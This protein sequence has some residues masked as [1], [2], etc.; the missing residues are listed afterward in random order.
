MNMKAL[1]TGGAGF[2]GSHIVEELL[3]QKHEVVVIDN[4]VTGKQEN[5]PSD[6]KFYNAD[7][8]SD[9][10]SIFTIEKPDIV[11]H[12]AAQV[13]VS[14]SM[15]HPGY[16][17]EENI[18]ATIN[19]LEAC[20]KHQVNKFIFASSAAVYG[21]PS[22]LS[23][24]EDHPV[25][26]LSFYGLSKRNAEAYIEMFS[27][28]FG[29]NYTILRYA[30]VYGMR[31]DT[32]GEAGVVALFIDQVL[33]GE[34]LSVFGDGKQTRDF[35]FVKDVA[36]ANVA[37]CHF[38]DREIINIS[39]HSQTSVLDII[40]QLSLSIRKEI[41]PVFLNERPGD[42]RDS[43]L[44][45]QKARQLLRWEPEYDFS[46]GLGLTMDDYQKKLVQVY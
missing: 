15:S 28:A 41:S 25:A 24:D 27:H 31:Q 35:V 33:K 43:L 21:T 39:H 40:K 12:Q 11:I 10:D 34:D 4:L 38:G 32:N 8:R 36:K 22:Y 23:I 5:I 26:P 6:A 42:I 2:I 19:L 17:A 1:V 29:L 46:E 18:K 3:S 45:N 44:S 9:I 20:V 13:S 7:V 16:D 30:N 14:Y 37:A